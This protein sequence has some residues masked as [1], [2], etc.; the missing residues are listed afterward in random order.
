MRK[1][2]EAEGTAQAK[3][4]HTALPVTGNAAHGLEREQ[5][6]CWETGV[7]RDP[8]S[9]ACRVRICAW[10]NS[11]RVTDFDLQVLL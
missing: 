9:K 3:V 5:W 6:G 2:S 7:S 4:R 1:A 8:A 11:R 10:H